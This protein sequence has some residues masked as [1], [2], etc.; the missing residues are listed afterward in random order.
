MIKGANYRERKTEDARCKTNG[1]R[2]KAAWDEIDPALIRRSF[3]K[4]CLRNA[5]NGTEDDAMWL[6]DAD[7][8]C[9]DDENEFCDDA[10]YCGCDNDAKINVVRL[11][12]EESDSDNEF[13]GFRETDS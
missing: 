7:E 4:C 11:L 3:K 5:M 13:E 2:I 9:S 6:N 10:M 8:S 12:L 1:Q